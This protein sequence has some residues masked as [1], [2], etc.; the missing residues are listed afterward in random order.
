MTEILNILL[1]IALLG[2]AFFGIAT[3]VLAVKDV[4]NFLRKDD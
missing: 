2:L 3:F 4:M 1:I